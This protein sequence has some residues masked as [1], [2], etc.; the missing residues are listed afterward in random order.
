MEPSTHAGAIPEDSDDIERK[1]RTLMKELVP[2]AFE[3]AFTALAD[4]EEAIISAGCPKAG[5][6]PLAPVL[7]PPEM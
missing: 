4:E 3:N 6:L 1:F 2:K 5:V 7:Q